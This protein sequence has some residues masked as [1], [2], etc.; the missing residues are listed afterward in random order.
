M[1]QISYLTTAAMTLLTA[2]ASAGPGDPPPGKAGAP[3]LPPPAEAPPRNPLSFSDGRV[4]FDLEERVRFE[5]RENTF[6]F[7]DGVDS[8]TDDSFLLQRARLG[9]LLKPAPWLS[10]YA[11]GQ[12]IREIDSDRPNVVGQMGAEGDE[13]FDLL[14]GWARVGEESGGLSFKAG[15]QKFNYG[16][17]R[18]VGALEWAN[19]SRTFDA[20]KLRFAADDWWVDLFTAS[21]VEFEDGVFNRSDFTDPDSVRDQF[22]SGAYLSTKW[23]PFQSATDFYV[24]HLDQNT[25]AGS[26]SFW[27]LG[28]RWKGDPAKLGG[29]FYTAEMAAQFGEAGGQDLAAFAGHWGLGYRFDAPWKPSVQVLYNFAT[30]DEDPADG[31]VGRFQNLFPTNHLFYGFMDTASWVNLHN[32]AVSFSLQPT[33]KLTLGL[34]YHLF[35]NVE[36]GDA[37]FR[38]N[39]V[40]PVRP[41]TP[42]ADRFRGSEL[43]FTAS[44]KFGKSVSLL[45]GYSRFFAGEYLSDTGAADDADFGYAQLAIKF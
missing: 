27:T 14:E 9:L 26:T 35:W 28:T 7:N 6:D 39:G 29:F 41:V 4:V 23:L 3:G 33:P 37:W 21:V 22:F 42:G 34:D 16:D 18:L 30:G 12:D 38:A 45:L 31:D 15:R 40:T 5:G 10:L 44:Y 2:A 13:T 25:P 43:D 24:Y 32:P 11:Q 20:A 17:Q 1:D 8:L 19:Q 36:D